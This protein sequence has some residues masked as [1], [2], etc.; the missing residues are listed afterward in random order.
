MTAK[1]IISSDKTLMPASS[2]KAVDAEMPVMNV[3][4]NLLDAP[5]HMLNVR[6]ADGIVGVIDEHSI[7]EA[8][9]KFMPA[10]DDSSVIEVE[11]NTT[12]YSASAFAHA[13]EDADVHL[14][15]LITTPAD[16]G[17][18][19]VTLR[20]R[21]P[22]PTP[23]VRSLERYGYEVV[24]AYGSFNADALISAERLSELQVYLNV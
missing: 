11:C 2:F 18:I 12:D 15:D 19:R 13:V 10:R 3:L 9:A 24:S 21:I 6:D 17:R 8:L 20:V 16:D 23:V 5:G 4:S 22:D 1:E 14:V 7:L